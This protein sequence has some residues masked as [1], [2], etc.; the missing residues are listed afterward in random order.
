MLN[1]SKISI[2]LAIAILKS[3]LTL[4]AAS[5]STGIGVV[6]APLVRKGDTPISQ[7]Y[8]QNITKVMLEVIFDG[9][10]RSVTTYGVGGPDS[11][12]KKV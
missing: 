1:D 5:N 6:F 4:N 8:T 11:N 3:A 10:Y 9:G 2:L 7:A 12:A